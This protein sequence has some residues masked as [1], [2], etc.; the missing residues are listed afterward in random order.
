MAK[1]R[2]KSINIENKGSY[3]QATV[4]YDTLGKFA[5]ED[6]TKKV[7]SFGPS[8][9]VF[10]VLV[11][12]KSFPTDAE[13]TSTKAGEY[14]NWTAL[15]VISGGASQA[16]A[17]P[18]ASPTPGGYQRSGVT[19]EVRQKL[20]VR[21]SCLERAIEFHSLTGNKKATEV[22]IMR[23]AENL[24]D[25]VFKGLASAAEGAVA[26]MAAPTGVSDGDL[27]DDIPF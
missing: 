15:E 24:H 19:D 1:I 20:I 7:M 9:P 11:G 16:A 23:T 2:I 21:Q 17:A 14:W 5:K 6:Q 22:D 4:I 26:A 27:D 8:E 12:I 13:V 25:Y 10:P 3:K 18:S